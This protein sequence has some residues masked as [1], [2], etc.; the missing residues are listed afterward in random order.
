MTK[1]Q[2]KSKKRVVNYGEVFTNKKEVNAMCDLVIQETEKINS[3][4]L[5]PACGDGNFLIEILKRKLNT[6]KKRYKDIC[7]WERFSLLAISSL[8]GIEILEDNAIVCKN[9]LYN[10]W[11]KEYET[12]NNKKYNKK[13]L[14]FAKYILEHNIICGNTL[15][16]KC[17]SKEGHDTEKPIIF[18]FWI[19]SFD[20]MKIQKRDYT[21]NE[22]LNKERHRKIF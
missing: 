10:Y 18:F 16:G 1:E 8:Y 3:K 13:I 5:E 21:F 12:I 4:F 22:L 20:D 19:F 17:V 14:D 11:K 2:I 7:D 9:R 6:I 15:S